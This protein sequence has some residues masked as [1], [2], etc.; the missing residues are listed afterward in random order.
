MEIRKANHQD[1]DIIMEIYEC[2]KKFMKKTANPTQWNESYPNTELLKN[3]IDKQ[4][5]YVCISNNEII[6]VFVFIIGEDPTYRV[7]ENGSWK[8]DDLYGTIHRIA[9]NGKE[10]GVAKRCYDYCKGLIDNI[11]VDTHHD[12]KIMKKSLLNN[13]FEE[14]GI[15]YV[16]DGS[17][18]IAHHYVK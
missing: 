1:L 14:C 18:R 17:P 16:E 10:K 7:I 4:Q 9:T 11:R 6:G 12:N 5:C 2:A 8:N 13:G 15:I 3:D